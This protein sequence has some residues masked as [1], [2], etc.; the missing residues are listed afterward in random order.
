ML[1]VEEYIQTEKL[2]LKFYRKSVTLRRF[3]VYRFS[4]KNFK[5]N[6]W[7]VM[8]FDMVRDQPPNLYSPIWS[9]TPSG[10]V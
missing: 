7:L 3:W 2:R 8:L 4:R 1:Q 6:P 9:S 5:W 10:L